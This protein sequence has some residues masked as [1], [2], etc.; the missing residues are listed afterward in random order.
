M[1]WASLLFVHSPLVG[2]SSLRR[3]AEAAARAGHETALPDL[4]PMAASNRP[5]EVYRDLAVEAARALTGPPV[6]VG[7]SGAGAFLP[8]IGEAIRETAGLVFVDALVPPAEGAHRTPD[9]L[10]ALLDEQTVEGVLRPWL[11]WWPAEA[12]AELLPEAADRDE[13]AADMP[14][15]P[16]SFYDVPIA[17]PP[18]WSEQPCGYL[19]L[20]P[21]YDAEL[22][23]ARQWGWPTA[24]LESTHLGTLTEPDRVLVEVLGLTGHLRRA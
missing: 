19:R 15:V 8:A 1:V 11:D 3:L 7:H 10:A 9:R 17:V 4:T 2:P 20:S 14:R 12:V 6:V 16:R 5:H 24:T 13:L 23:R 22:E 21:A 18:G